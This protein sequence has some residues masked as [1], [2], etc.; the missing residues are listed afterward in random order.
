MLTRSLAIMVLLLLGMPSSGWAAEPAGAT[1]VLQLPPS[2]SPDEVRGLIAD[3]AAKGAHP[4]AQPNDPPEAAA[5]P[6]FTTAN[7]AAQV[8]DGTKRAVQALPVLRQAPQIWIEQVEAEGGTPGLALRFWIVAFAGLAA[9][10][11]I[12]RGFRELLDRRQP[13]V[14]AQQ[15]APRLRAVVIRFFVAGTSLTLF[16][17]FYWTALFFVSSGRPILEETADRLVGAALIWRLLI[18][19]LMIVVSPQRADLRLLAI[20]DTDAR[21]CFRWLAVYLTI[22]PFNVFLVWLVERLGLEHDA[23]FGAALALGL[24]ITAYKVAM[25]WAVRRPIARAILAATGSEPGPFRRAVAASWHWLFIALA[26]GIFVA[27]TIELSL[28]KGAWVA[29]A[30]AATPGIVVALAVLWQ[31]SQNLTARL[32]LGETVDVRLA[33]RRERFRRALR[34]LSDAFLWIL[35]AAWLGVTWVST[36]STRR[37]AVSSGCL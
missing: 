22:N 12:G 3:L 21:V 29:R 23:V 14:T 8:W 32:F 18:I 20:D 27:A 31:G 30:S 4:V 26:L 16:G 5:Q 7:I 34:R 25:F 6:A 11:L 17:A 19:I 24:P 15:L 28:G 9:A 1:I 37:P 10:P 36:W 33:L 35:G 2:M 13:R